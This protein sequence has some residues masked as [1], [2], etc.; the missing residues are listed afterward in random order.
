MK[1]KYWFKKRRSMRKYD[2]M[3]RFAKKQ[4]PT[5]IPDSDNMYV[6]IGLDWGGDTCLYCKE[7]N[8]LGIM[9]CK[10]CKLGIGG[11]IRY[12][13]LQWSVVRNA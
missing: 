7:L 4:I 6:S 10:H 3:I 13:L 11:A 9:S 12:M 2:R 1:T 8:D 5:D